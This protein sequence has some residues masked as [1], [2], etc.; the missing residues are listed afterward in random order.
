MTSDAQIALNDV[1]FRSLLQK[2]AEEISELEVAVNAEPSTTE[3]Y[4][5]L[6]EAVV[7]SRGLRE[8]LL[9]VFA[10]YQDAQRDNCRP[11]SS[12]ERSALH[13]F[14]F[15]VPLSGRPPVAEASHQ[16]IRLPSQRLASHERSPQNETETDVTDTFLDMRAAQRQELPEH[17]TSP[18]ATIRRV[19][20]SE[21]RDP[22]PNSAV[23]L[24]SPSPAKY[25]TKGMLVEKYV[26]NDKGKLEDEL[27]QHIRESL[28]RE[29]NQERTSLKLGHDS[30]IL[31]L[32]QQLIDLRT[33]IMESREKASASIAE[34]EA[35]YGSR[36]S[37]LE[38]RSMRQAKEL[39]D[40][41]EA[42]DER[43]QQCSAL[44][45]ELRRKDVEIERLRIEN[46]ERS[47][48]L[49][50]SRLEFSESLRDI[51]NLLDDVSKGDRNELSSACVALRGI[52]EAQQQQWH[53]FARRDERQMTSSDATMGLMAAMET[54]HCVEV[55]SAQPPMFTLDGCDDVDDVDGAVIRTLNDLAF[56]FEVSIRRLGRGG[57][58]FIDRRV[59]VR[60]ID[61]QPMVRPHVLGGRQAAPYEHLG[62]YLMTL[63]A[64]LLD[65]DEH[66]T[67]S[68]V[69][70]ATH[71]SSSAVATRVAALQ[72]QHQE[73]LRSLSEKQLL[74]LEH[75]RRTAAEMS[76]SPTAA[77]DRNAGWRRPPSPSP[78]PQF[79][80]RTSTLQ[81]DV[82]AALKRGQQDLQQQ[83]P[84]QKKAQPQPR[85]QHDL[86]QLTSQELE[87]L[88][89]AALAQQ[90]KEMKKLQGK[91]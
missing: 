62:Q 68:P 85:S 8:E 9:Q 44:E 88:K 16:Y 47:Q 46:E 34:T 74:L 91:R 77:R 20:P 42:C 89:R 29:W 53:Q 25:S 38:E 10:M 86:S 55:Q 73:L 87:Q 18:A 2:F 49:S 15:A 69:E 11:F 31:Q 80:A 83:C 78:L 59:Q 81:N 70:T 21:E 41:R 19:P 45:S 65:F 60:A 52:I 66:P 36:L 67:D 82:N 30:H 75:N 54:L 84:A 14:G 56:P 72:E 61:G 17:V 27:R 64:P 39:N 13:Y 1:T 90:L 5:Q 58:Y 3:L 40:A 6:S 79:E 50:N 76:P 7:Q 33:S 4:Q 48:Q 24:S 28:E 22:S 26:L 37:H 63:Y 71:S 35:V 23:F 12:E 43:T 57:D 51:T 32:Q